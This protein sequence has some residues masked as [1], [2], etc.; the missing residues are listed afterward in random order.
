MSVGVKLSSEDLAAIA[1]LYDL[2]WAADIRNWKE[3]GVEG[4]LW[5]V[6]GP[7]T[8]N[9]WLSETGTSLSQTIDNLLKQALE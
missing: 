4:C 6:K 1:K 7:N 9:E 5:V 8:R 2:R 3:R